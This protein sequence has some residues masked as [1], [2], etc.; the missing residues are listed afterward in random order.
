[1]RKIKGNQER[2]RLAVFRSNRHI[3]AQIIND[4]EGVGIT[5]VS[6]LTEGIKEQKFSNP[7]ERAKEIGK[8]I[9]KKALDKKIKKVVFD[10]KKYKY[11]GSVKELAEG[12]REGGLEF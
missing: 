3:Y 11:H 7:K 9:A 6:S 12:A 1:M 10:R 2:F 8:L 4:F 5:G